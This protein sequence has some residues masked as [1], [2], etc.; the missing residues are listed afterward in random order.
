VPATRSSPIPAAV[1][2][3]DHARPLVVGEC[4]GLL[5]RLAMLPDP[6]TGGDDDIP[7]PASWPSAPRR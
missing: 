3:P 1:T 4:A 5:E 2:H 7:W 6:V